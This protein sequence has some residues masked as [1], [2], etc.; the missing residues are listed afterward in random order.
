MGDTPRID[1]E[2]YRLMSELAYENAK[3]GTEYANLP[4]WQVLEDTHGNGYSGF[5][6]VTFTIRKR[7]RRSFLTEE[8]KEV[9]DGIVKGLIFWRMVR[10]R[11]PNWAEKLNNLPISH[12]IG[13]QVEFKR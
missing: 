12:P 13:Y 10:L 6:A 1:D 8:Q 7:G 2:T 3:A 5:D 9:P 11:S 4:G